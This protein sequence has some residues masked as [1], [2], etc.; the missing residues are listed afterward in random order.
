[1]KGKEGE[2]FSRVVL[3]VGGTDGVELGAADVV[4]STLGFPFVV[5]LTALFLRARHVLTRV[6]RRREYFSGCTEHRVVYIMGLEM[7]SS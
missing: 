4:A 2:G 7:Y 1:M 5:Q 6:C 3:P